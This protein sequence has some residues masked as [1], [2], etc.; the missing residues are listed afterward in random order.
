MKLKQKIEFQLMNLFFI[1]AIVFFMQGNQI[2]A[3]ITTDETATN[4]NFE[5]FYED[6]FEFAILTGKDDAD[7]TIWTYE[8][9]KYAATELNRTSEI[10]VKNG[11]YYFCEDGTIIAF[12]VS[13]GTIL[14]QNSSFGGS[15]SSYAFGNN[16]ELYLCSRLQQSGHP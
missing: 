8:T 12:S 1:F 13:D 3:E 2:R 5:R 7:N 6:N 4:V 15:L 10:T 9:E 16:G 11:I 14:W